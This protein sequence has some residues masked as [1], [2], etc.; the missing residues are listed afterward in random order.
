MM[1]QIGGSWR[2]IAW[3]VGIG[4]RL[5]EPVTVEPANQKNDKQRLRCL[6]PGREKKGTQNMKNQQTIKRGVVPFGQARP[7]SRILAGAVALLVISGVL[8]G[9]AWAITG[10]GS[11]NG[12]HPYV[13][14]M[15]AV[16]PKYRLT[17]FTGILVHP[18]VIVTA[19]HATALAISGGPGLLG[20]SFD[21]NV[22]VYD[23]S[24]WQP[25]SVSR[26]I[27]A[28]T[29]NGYGSKDTDIGIIILDKPVEG[30]TPATLPPQGL[31]DWLKAT[32]QLEAGPNAAEFTEVGYGFGLDWPPPQPIFPVSDQGICARN[33]AQSAYMR[34]N[35]A[36][37]YLAQ[38]QA[39]GYGGACLG[40]SGSPALW[41]DPSTGVEYVVGICSSGDAAWVGLFQLLP[42]G[43][44]LGAPVHS[45]RNR[46]HR[47][48]M[49]TFPAQL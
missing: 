32:H 24:T 26:V 16:H 19:G 35:S 31:L 12:K 30:I 6:P 20:I 27:S 41:T 28:Y 3:T 17:P 25:V 46:Q 40:D 43:H 42:R 9:R 29:G 5:G 49:I 45:G 14:A 23:P 38:N 37:L 13:G 2:S 22:N 36:W 7:T 47:S 21:Q 18:R 33:A 1:K 34:L 10:G 39:R 48:G 15:I 8:G 44:A 11:D 4:R